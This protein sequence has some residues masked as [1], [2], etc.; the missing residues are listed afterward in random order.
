MRNRRKETILEGRKGFSV[1]CTAFN[2]EF[3][4]RIKRTGAKG[5]ELLTARRF[6]EETLADSRSWE[7]W[8]NWAEDLRSQ[9]GTRKLRNVGTV[10]FCHR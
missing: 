10:V 4:I 3:L 5:W 8:A 2:R 7:T 6:F 1:N 9:K